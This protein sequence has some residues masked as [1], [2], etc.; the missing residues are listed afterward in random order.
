[1]KR[2]EKAAI[3]EEL[4]E[5]FTN[6]NFFY[7]TDASGLTVA[8]VNQFRKL[9]FDRGLEYRVAKNTLIQKALETLEVDY[10]SLNDQALKGFT[11][12]MFTP[13]IGNMPAKI[14]KDFKKKDKDD[15][16][17]FKAASIDSELFLG[18]DQLNI[19]SN[20]KSKVELIGEIINLLQS[21]A[22]N[23][24]S[25]LQSGKNKLAGIIK[26]LSEK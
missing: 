12:I 23:V 5:K 20:L 18:E 1:M 7:F 24:I 14:I 4:V 11:G 2:E 19:L 22:K 25:S 15:R 16:P 6:T 10:S 21:P 3:I 26:T 9:C 13:E 17:I 8:E